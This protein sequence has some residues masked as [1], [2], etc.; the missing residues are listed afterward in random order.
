[1]I[2]NQGTCLPADSSHEKEREMKTKCCYSIQTQKKLP[3]KKTHHLH[4]SGRI[5][6]DYKKEEASKREKSN[7]K[8]ISLVVEQLSSHDVFV[9]VELVIVEELFEIEIRREV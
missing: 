2:V 6:E 8:N 3:R 9:Y 7:M 1:M 4:Q 5:I